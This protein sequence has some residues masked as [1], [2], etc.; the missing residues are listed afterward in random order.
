MA[1]SNQAIFN[2]Q[3]DVVEIL[4][5]G[6]DTT[7]RKQ[8]EEALQRSEAKFRTIFENSQVG[9]YRTRTCD[10]LILEANQRFANLFGFDSPEEVIGLKHTTDCYVNPS[11][12]QQAIELLKRDG[13]LQNFEV[14]LQKRDGTLFWGL[15]STRLNAADECIEGVIAD[16]SDRKQAEAAL[17]ASETKLRTLIEAIPDPLFVLSAEGRILEIMVLE[18]DL[19]WQP[20]EEMI[21]QT[22]HQSERNK[23]MNF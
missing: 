3:G 12:R 17:Q 21:G 19:L 7:Q 22:M 23:L 6:N 18:P 5:V 11:D 10:G 16:I 13:E 2:D 8:A 9:I 4:S 20:Y 15:C 1:W 14:Q